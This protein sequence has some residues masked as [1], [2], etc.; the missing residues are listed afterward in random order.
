[1]TYRLKKICLDICKGIDSLHNNLIIHRD[2]KPS[3]IFIDSKGNAKI[4]DLG[5]AK[6]IDFVPEKLAKKL[7]NKSQ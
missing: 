4:G 1:M 2:I 3:N 5:I 6:L 7:P